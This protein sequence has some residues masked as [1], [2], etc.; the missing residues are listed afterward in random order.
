MR[1]SYDARDEL[2]GISQTDSSSGSP[3]TTT[4]GQYRYDAD[5]L[6]TDRQSMA[7]GSEHY[8]WDDH[9]LLLSYDDGGAYKARYR[10]G[11]QR[12][13]SVTTGSGAVP[14]LSWYFFDALG[15]VTDVG[16]TSR[17]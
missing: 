11:P 15:S 9:S 3:V 13:E 12:L 6:R 2:T 16:V 8:T 7:T 14:L 17:C 5:G 1:S 4:V 10:Y